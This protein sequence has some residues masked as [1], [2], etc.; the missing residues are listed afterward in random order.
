MDSVARTPKHLRP[1][2]D[3]D[4]DVR[5]ISVSRDVSRNALRQ[6]LT[7]EAEH[8]GWEL[9]RLRRYRD[10]SREVW[11]R[12]RIIRVRPTLDAQVGTVTP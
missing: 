2:P 7:E 10:G 4:Y 11:I 8:G 6:M 3:S 1:R 5:R 12:R 9:H